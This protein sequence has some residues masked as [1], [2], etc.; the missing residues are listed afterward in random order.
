MLSE[1]I[2][3]SALSQV[4]YPGFSRDILSFG[5]VKSIQLA[6]AD[7]TVEISLA[8]RDPNIPRLIHEQ[9]MEVLQKLPGAGQ[10][11]L[12]FDIKEPPGAG[13]TASE[14]LGKSSIPG[15]KKIIAVASGKGGVG[16]STVASNLAVALSKTGAR[17]GLCDCDL[18]GPSIAHMFGTSERPYQNEEQ[19]IVPVEKHGLQLIS[20]GFLLEDASPVIVRGPVATRYTQQF[21]RQVAWDNLDVLVLDLPPGTGDIQLTIV[22]T[23][24][25]DGALIVTTPQEV[26]L[27]DARKAVAMFQKVNVPI[28]G[29]V[30]N[31]SYFRCPSDGKDYHIFGKGGGEHE[32]KRLGVPLLGQIPIEMP[33][34]E[35][36]DE[37]HPV[38]LE[39]PESSVASRVFHEIAA[40]L[41]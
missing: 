36:G 31:M 6:G 14:K 22:Q 26:A 35:C 1:D 2:V 9:A 24:A 19:Q 29:I 4:R 41:R 13:A 21:L 25:L 10:V 20:M 40:K 11:R 39:S 32:A 28:L 12:N 16:K 27:I 18:Y 23:V 17:V 34:R 3:R 37:G 30:E 15:V 8:T 33:V 5:L 38:A 7:V